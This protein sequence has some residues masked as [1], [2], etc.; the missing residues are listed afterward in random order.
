MRAQGSGVSPQERNAQT[1]DNSL[2]PEL[3]YNA[4]PLP[5]LHRKVGAKRATGDLVAGL[6][7]HAFIKSM[8]NPK[9]HTK[10][11]A[12]RTTGVLEA[13]SPSHP[14]GASLGALSAVELDHC[15][16]LE[17]LT[18]WTSPNEIR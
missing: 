8:V 9:L 13:A 7:D 12:R 18:S 17:I 10:A 2:L 14:R 15:A 3:L 6:P 5:L 16:V 1:N 11:R 4:I